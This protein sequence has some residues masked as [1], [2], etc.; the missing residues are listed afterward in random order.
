MRWHMALVVGTVAVAVGCAHPESSSAVATQDNLK[1]QTAVPGQYLITLAPDAD[2]QAIADV[3]GRFGIKSTQNLGR[4]T[5]LVTLTDDPGLSAME[6]LRKGDPRLAAV[7][8]NFVY[9]IQN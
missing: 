8:P 5:F 3:Y 1:S 9:G 4:G 6:G 2:A 7:Q